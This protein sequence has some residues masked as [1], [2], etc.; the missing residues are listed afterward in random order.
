MSQICQARPLSNYRRKPQLVKQIWL[1]L[2]VLSWLLTACN[3]NVI[4]TASG[5]YM[6]ETLPDAGEVMQLVEVH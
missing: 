6:C 3:D 2:F 4:S 5:R 1:I